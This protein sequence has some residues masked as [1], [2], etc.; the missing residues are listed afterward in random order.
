MR[1]ID[2]LH[3]AVGLLSIAD[4]AFE[5][6]AALLLDDRQRRG[7]RRFQIAGRVVEN[8]AHALTAALEA[9]R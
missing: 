6:D 4:E 7:L 1:R 2:D 8:A 9:A 3:D 5:S